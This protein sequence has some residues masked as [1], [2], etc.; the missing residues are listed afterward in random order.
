[1]KRRVAWILSQTVLSASQLVVV[2]VQNLMMS[3]MRCP[4]L[5][6]LR[7]GPDTSGI[8]LVAL[9]ALLGILRLFH[10]DLPKDGGTL[11]RTTTKVSELVDKCI[12]LVLW[13]SLYCIN[14]QSKSFQLVQTLINSF[15]SL[16]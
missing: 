1:M 9:T 5:T 14:M 2:I 13:P 8:A 16:F 10:P 3:S 4:Y 6:R 15:C 12:L 11:L 7:T